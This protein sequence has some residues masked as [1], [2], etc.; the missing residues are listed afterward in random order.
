MSP[1]KPRARR[2]RLLD[3]WKSYAGGE[4]ARYRF[5]IVASLC[6]FVV[7]IALA[8]FGDGGWLAVHR[9]RRDVLHL[10]EEIVR[11]GEGNKQLRQEITDLRTDP[12]TLERIARDELGMGRPGEV[13]YEI[14]DRR[15]EQVEEQAE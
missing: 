2:T 10:Q 15:E 8:I 6:F 9:A 12:S 7:L 14:I 1:E 3:L 4:R 5:L 11:L 13:V